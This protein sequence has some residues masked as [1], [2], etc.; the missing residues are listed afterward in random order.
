MARERGVVIQA[1]AQGVAEKN[2]G[3]E[4]AAQAARRR[5]KE[6]FLLAHRF[7]SRVIKKELARPRQKPRMM[8]QFDLLHYEMHQ[9]MTVSL[10]LFD[11]DQAGT[12]NLPPLD[13][14]VRRILTHAPVIL[15][16]L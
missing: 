16:D 11:W 6:R 1:R 15:L 14:K 8:E 4:S 13:I 2:E 12:D 7:K 5:I 9:E 10:S 3:L